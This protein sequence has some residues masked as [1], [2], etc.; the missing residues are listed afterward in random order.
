MWRRDFFW[1]CWEASSF[2]DQVNYSRGRGFPGPCNLSNQESH[3]NKLQG[4][5][6]RKWKLLERRGRGRGIELKEIWANIF[7]VKIFG[8]RKNYEKNHHHSFTSKIN[9]RANSSRVFRFWG[10]GGWGHFRSHFE[11]RQSR[12][13]PESRPRWFLRAP[14]G[15]NS[16]KL[17]EK[18]WFFV[19]FW[20]FRAHF[21]RD[22]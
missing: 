3:Q 11:N 16:R 1:S 22:F 4:G 20:V 6:G 21:R 10:F 14:R 5:R 19:D 8:N 15:S 12:A 18:V 7:L 9:V 13:R 2:I 17:G